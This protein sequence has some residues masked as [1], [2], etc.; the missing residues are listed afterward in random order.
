MVPTSELEGAMCPLRRHIAQTPSSH[1]FKEVGWPTHTTHGHTT[2]ST[3]SLP[4][5]AGLPMIIG[6]GSLCCVSLRI[7][8]L[9]HRDRCRCLIST[10]GIS[11]QPPAHSRRSLLLPLP[12]S[13]LLVRPRKTHEHSRSILNGYAGVKATIGHPGCGAHGTRFRHILRGFRD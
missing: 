12:C 2:L 8:L 13:P 9:I 10:S 11:A 1:K 7:R 6:L 5:P 4:P 3:C